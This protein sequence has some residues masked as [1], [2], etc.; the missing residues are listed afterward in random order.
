MATAAWSM[1]ALIKMNC[2]IAWFH[3]LALQKLVMAISQGKQTYYKMYAVFTVSIIIFSS[4]VV[5]NKL[6]ACVNIVPKITSV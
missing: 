2:F 3:S 5:A 1:G 6:A 4:G